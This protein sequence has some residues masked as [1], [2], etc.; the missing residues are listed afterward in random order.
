MT[1]RWR[2]TVLGAEPKIPEVSNRCVHE[3]R[4]RKMQVRYEALAPAE[5]STCVAAGVRLSRGCGALAGHGSATQL[6]TQAVAVL[7]ARQALV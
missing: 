3:T 6:D 4:L 2:N 1:Q 7:T 5:H